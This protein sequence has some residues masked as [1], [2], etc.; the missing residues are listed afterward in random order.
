MSLVLALGSPWL[1]ARSAASW[2]SVTVF[3][4][5]VRWPSAC[6]FLD[7][8][9]ELALW[10]Y[11]SPRERWRLFPDLLPAELSAALQDA[12]AAAEK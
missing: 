11:R 8:N 7:V 2:R 12:T 9:S 10:H 6:V 4:S 1:S 3:S 5:Q